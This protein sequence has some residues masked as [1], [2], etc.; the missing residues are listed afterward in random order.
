MS[1]KKSRKNIPL[2]MDVKLP[3]RVLRSAF[4]VPLCVA[5]PC[6]SKLDTS[7]SSSFIIASCGT[8]G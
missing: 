5:L 2:N 1:L 7:S 4:Y 8:A 6:F 3:F